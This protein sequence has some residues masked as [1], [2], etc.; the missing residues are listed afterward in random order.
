MH[1]FSIGEK[2]RIAAT[3]CPSELS[4]EVGMVKEQIELNSY[5]Y[6]VIM[7]DGFF[8]GSHKTK[9]FVVAEHRLRQ[10]EVGGIKNPNAAFKR[11]KR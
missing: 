6:Y 7:I 11:R 2:V 4:G 5:P 9:G 3:N 10:V 1:Y 8:D